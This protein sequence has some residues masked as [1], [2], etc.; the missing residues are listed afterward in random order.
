MRFQ[1]SIVTERLPYYQEEVNNVEE[2]CALVIEVVN[3]LNIEFDHRFNEFNTELWISFE[4]LKPSTIFPG[5]RTTE[6]H[7]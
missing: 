1:D 7:A 2:L 5:C 3:N 6:T 4:N